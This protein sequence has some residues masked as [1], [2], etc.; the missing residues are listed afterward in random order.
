MA[1]QAKG[2]ELWS[3]RAGFLLAAIGFSVGLGNIWRFPYITGAYGGSAFLIVYLCCALAVAL[4]L[5][6]T[7]LMI[8]RRG[9]ASP[10]GSIRA[11]AMES[12]ASAAWGGVGTLAVSCVFVILSYF[13]V[14]AGWTFDYFL[15][16][17]S[18]SFAGIDLVESRA[19]FASLMNDPW[20][21]LFWHTVVNAL[22]ILV[23]RRG[24]QEGVEKSMKLLM[25]ILFIALLAM[26]AFSSA[27]G[28]F[29]AAV[30]YLLEPDF[31]KVTLQTVMVAQG[32]AFFSIGIGMAAMISFG[33][34]M[35][36]GYAIP[37]CALT[38]VAADT[39][40]ALLS[41]F[42]IFPLVF[43]FGLEPSSGA[44][45]I[46]HTLPL[47]FG[48]MPGG[49][50]FGAVFFLL[51][52]AAALSSCIGCGE[53][54]VSWVDEHWGIKRG[55]GI[56]VAIAGA[57]LMGVLAIMSLGV[58]WDFYPLGFMPAF[59]GKTIFDS[60]DFLAANVLLL[61]GAFLTSI[62]F[63]WLVPKQIHLNELGTPNG[64]FFALWRFLLRFVIPPMLLISLVLGITG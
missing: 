11:V 62:F 8:G 55:K 37:R 28:N 47:A 13:T 53:A 32:Q 54:V 1:A 21:L 61:F 14:L 58:W 39:G 34:Y 18:G 51:L 56:V 49:S 19:M 10:S 9:R 31:S 42:A 48:Q 17:A 3:S 7:E 15:R 50:L 26:V 5:L 27:A 2:G 33:G 12:G 52:I 63:G 41:G 6:V 44:G 40:V 59:A 46:F 35:P 29:T 36:S 23:V 38:I 25:P 43:Q 45:L 30:A 64:M 20:R 60:L 4:P 16:S 24:V 57:W 22:I